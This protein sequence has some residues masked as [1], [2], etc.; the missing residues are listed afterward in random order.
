MK[1][2]P[3]LSLKTNNLPY[4]AELKQAACEV[5]ESGWFLNGK[6]TAALEE[7]LRLHCG[8]PY[9]VACSNGLDAL[10]LIF[11]AYIELGVMKPGDEVIVPANTYIAS[12][13]AVTD[14]GLVPVM[15]EPSEQ[16]MN[17]DVKRVEAAITPRT[18]AVMVVHLYG[19]ACWG[20]EL[21]DLAVRY[22]LK[23]VEDNAQAIG[24]QASC[25]GLNGSHITG[26]LG[27][28]AGF[29]FYPTKNLGALGDAGAVTTSDEQLAKAVKALAN[30]GSDRR[31]HNIYQGV[32]CRMDE[33]QAA[34][35]CVKMRHLDDITRQRRE[36]AAAYEQGIAN[37][38][39]RKPLADAG[40]VWHQY[41]VRVAERERFR[42]YLLDNGV[43]TDIH[44]AV[45]PHL[46]P[47]YSQYAGLHLPVT[48]KMADEV[49]SLPITEGTPVED[50]HEICLIINHFK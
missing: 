45:P 46:Q 3:F 16:T 4:E 37:P 12:V 47:C 35:L 41:V 2:Y 25:E 33:L 44:Y 23:I 38:L 10:R 13:L 40:A 27:D 24:A 42:A 36:R 17:L 15:V 22:G 11:R 7:A 28:A 39:V 8:M 31:Y 9:A 26:G 1:R 49:V 34:M 19:A 14:N 5:V 20:P 32:N 18:R 21:N 6:H 30:Y 29:S 43:E 50:I 48:V